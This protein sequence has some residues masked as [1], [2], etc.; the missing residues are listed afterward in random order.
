MCFQ[1]SD[2]ETLGSEA[3]VEYP[4]ELVE[5]PVEEATPVQDTQAPASAGRNSQIKSSVAC[6][7]QD[8]YNNTCISF[9]L[10]ASYH[11]L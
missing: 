2:I 7:M 1:G 11:H 3:A 6:L 8:S 9:Q 10:S 4:A 5:R